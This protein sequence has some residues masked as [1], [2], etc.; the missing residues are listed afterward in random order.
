MYIIVYKFKAFP[1]DA[2]ILNVQII[3]SCIF[4]GAIFT[5]HIR[6]SDLGLSVIIQ[7]GE[8]I[9]GRVG[10]A[11]YM[12][13]SCFCQDTHILTPWQVKQQGKVIISQFLSYTGI[14][15]AG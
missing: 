8:L 14:L 12:G 6:I 15:Y 5:G 10:T 1:K 9:R 11:G 7:E 13:M 3:I 2:F 4:N